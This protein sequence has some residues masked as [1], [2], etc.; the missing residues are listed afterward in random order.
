[1]N[2]ELINDIEKRLNEIYNGENADANIDYELLNKISNELNDKDNIISSNTE[3]EKINPLIGL[4]NVKEE[5][6]KLTDYLVFAKKL[7]KK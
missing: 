5:V 3:I 7:G 1:M 2:T 4:T 6:K